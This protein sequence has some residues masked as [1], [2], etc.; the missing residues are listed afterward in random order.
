MTEFEMIRDHLIENG[1]HTVIGDPRDLA[2]AAGSCARR[3]AIGLVYRRLIIQDVL[4]RPE[5]TRALV[6]ASHAGA[7][8]LVNPFASDL[9]ATSRSST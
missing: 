1:L 2:S 9:W 5:D 8:C 6:A 3:V 4:S 7:V